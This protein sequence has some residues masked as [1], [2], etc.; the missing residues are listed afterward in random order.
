MLE[1]RNNS[2]EENSATASLLK[3]FIKKAF[4]VN[5]L[6]DRHPQRSELYGQSKSN[7]RKLEK[8]ESRLLC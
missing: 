3:G 1:E 6:E 4:P 8:L 5:K 7:A 2:D